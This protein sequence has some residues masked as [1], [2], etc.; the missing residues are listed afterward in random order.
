MSMA[1]PS[2]PRSGLR[3][4]RDLVVIDRLILSLRK[5]HA[6]KPEGRACLKEA[7][8]L[9]TALAA[10]RKDSKRAAA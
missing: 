6:G 9:R 4:D 2:E 5:H 8:E 7:I 10:L 1:R 3:L